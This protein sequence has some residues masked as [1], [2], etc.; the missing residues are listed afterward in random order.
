TLGVAHNDLT[1]LEG[2][3]NCTQLTNFNM[4]GNDISDISMLS[5]S[6]TMLGWV[7][8]S[9]NPV[10]SLDVLKD[11][12]QLVAVY[13]D[14]TKVT[15][16]EPLRG[17]D[18]LEVLSACG[19]GLESV[20]VVKDMPKLH[21]IYLEHNK[22]TDMSPFGDLR[23]TSGGDIVLDLSDNEIGT[24]FVTYPSEFS[25]NVH[26]DLSANPVKKFEDASEPQDDSNYDFIAFDYYEGLNADELGRFNYGFPVLYILNTPL[27]KRVPLQESN[28]L[29]FHLESLHFESQE[30]VDDYMTRMRTSSLVK[31]RAIAIDY[32]YGGNEFSTQEPSVYDDDKMDTLLALAS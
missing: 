25:T 31:S 6:S 30:D 26:I 2:A 22:I 18:M 20:D 9:D 3:T 24:F 17:K 4:E 5:K 16:L 13:C 7:N 21:K 10:E 1:S 15:S 27:D 11:A 14:N 8:V 12:N 23:N 32:S 28:A 29:K 19:L